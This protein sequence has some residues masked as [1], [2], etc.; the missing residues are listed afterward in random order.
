MLAAA[1]LAAVA[2]PACRLPRRSRGAGLAIGIRTSPSYRPLLVRL[3]RAIRTPAWSRR[4]SATGDAAG[5]LPRL[6]RHGQRVATGLILGLLFAGASA[7][8]G[9]RLRPRRLLWP[10]RALVHRE[11]GYDLPVRA[12]FGCDPRRHYRGPHRDRRYL[13]AASSGVESGD[14]SISRDVGT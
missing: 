2:Y 12:G 14:I 11:P 9:T 5:A 4:R 3:H 7:C 8:A 10:G 6:C 13:A 1:L